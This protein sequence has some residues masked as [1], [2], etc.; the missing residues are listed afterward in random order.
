MVSCRA[1]RIVAAPAAAGQIPGA[2]PGRRRS[3]A[4]LASDAG[5]GRARLYPVGAPRTLFTFAAS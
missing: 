2:I 5:L 3:G 1:A 4:A